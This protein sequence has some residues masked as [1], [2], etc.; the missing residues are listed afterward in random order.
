[1]EKVLGRKQSIRNKDWINAMQHIEDLVKKEELDVL[2]DL[3]FWNR[4]KGRKL[5]SHG[6][7]G[8]IPSCLKRSAKWQESM[9]A[10]W[11]Y[12]IWNIRRLWNGL[13]PINRKSWKSSIPVRIW[14]G[15]W[16]TRICYSRRKAM[17][18]L[19]GS[20]WYSTEGRQGIIRCM[21][22]ICCS[23]E[24]GEQTEIMS[25][26]AQT[27]IR[28]ERELQDTARFRTGAMNQYSHLSIITKYLFRL[29][30]SGRMGIPAEHTRGRQDNGPDLWKTGGKKYLKLT[31]GLLSMQ[32]RRYRVPESFWKRTVSNCWNPGRIAVL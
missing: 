20:T 11:Q 13:Y 28:M 10:L 31:A 12:A 29:F 26:K 24:D 27:S 4:Q 18:R 22:W 7:E 15:Y 3:R 16:N 2:V 25:V 1:M 5:H 30:M 21:I 32:R 19:N 8:K 9:I 23:S 14:I 6:A 17:W